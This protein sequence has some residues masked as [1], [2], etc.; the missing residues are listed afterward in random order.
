MKY[1]PLS[2]GHLGHCPVAWTEATWPVAGPSIGQVRQQVPLTG[3]TEL[4][5]FVSHFCNGVVNNSFQLNKICTFGKG[6][7]EEDYL[8]PEG[9]DHEP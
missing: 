9:L 6:Y 5:R 1:T 3:R 7:I 2:M 8:F 4:H